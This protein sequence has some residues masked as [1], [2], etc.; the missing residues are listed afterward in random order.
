NSYGVAAAG[1]N[2]FNKEL[3]DLS[4]EEAAYLAALPKG[5]NLYHPFKKTEKA[6]ERRNWIIGQMAENGYITQAEAAEAKKK[7]L[8]V[9]IRPTGA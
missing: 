1:L 5:P 7:P 9:N 6:T 8:T 3:K 2:Y 4:I